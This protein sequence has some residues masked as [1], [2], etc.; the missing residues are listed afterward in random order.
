[1][2]V[3]LVPMLGWVRTYDR[4]W[5]RG[6][7][8]AGV[9]VA[10][11]IV[12]KNL[13]YAGIAGVPLEHGLYAAAAAA[14]PVRRLRHLSTDLDGA[15]LRA[16]GGGGRRRAR[17][18][19]QRRDRGGGRSSRASPWSPGCC[20]VLLPCCGW[21]GSARFLLAGRGHR[22]P[23]RCRDRR[24]DRRA[25]QDHRDR[26]RAARTPSRSSGPGSA[27]SVRPRRRRWWSAWWLWWWCSGSGSSRRPSPGPWCW[28]S[29]GSWRRGCSTSASAAWRWWVTSPAGCPPSTYR[30]RGCC[31]TTRGS[32]ARPP[33][34]WS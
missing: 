2:S 24:R 1:M 27:P 13:G 23:V 9:A 29:A 33:W 28:W 34:R 7:L 22:L 17:L 8:I 3:R 18:G 10:A 12:P 30:T 6:D 32:V 19:D 14:H 26:S 15:E 4:R 20:S 25:A 11:L 16:G 21:A 5:L 31:G